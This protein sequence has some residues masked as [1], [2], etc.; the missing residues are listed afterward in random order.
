MANGAADR[1]LGLVTFNN[2]VTVFGDGT[3]DPQIITGDKL[4]D[5]DYLMKNG[6][7]CGQNRMKN[8]VGETAK[9]LTDKLMGLEETGPTALGPAVATAVAMAAEGAPGS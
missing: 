5:Y 1:K 2:E 7:E 6:S 8:K 9:I 3:Q 4:E